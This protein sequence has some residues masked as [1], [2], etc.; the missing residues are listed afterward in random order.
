MKNKIKLMALASAGIIALS[1]T[2]SL[3]SCGDS[4]FK[5]VMIWGP[6]E[7][8]ELYLNAVEQFKKDNPTFTADVKYGSNGDAGAYGNLSVDPQSGGSIF[9]FPNDQL[10]NIK[11]IG[12]IAKL[13]SEDTAWIKANHVNSACEAGKIGDNYYAYPVSADNGF[14][15][16][17]N[18]DAF[19]GTDIW[20]SDADN[21]KEGY[22]FRD[23]Y[24]AL[25][26]RGTQ[27]GHEKWADG[28]AIWPSGSA[29]Y[30]SGCFFAA[31]GDY[32]VKYN[33]K[34]EQE[35]ATCNF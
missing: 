25:D 14:V 7:H 23:L 29:W 5:G 11:R 18:K 21:L 24:A 35:G 26:Q 28:L 6:A 20:D 13:G 27:S 3:T 1:L 17:Y 30:E 9:T 2:A 10:V 4:T 33:E 32:S 19:V 34:G 22:T 12:A 15:F 8:E 31:G 16:V